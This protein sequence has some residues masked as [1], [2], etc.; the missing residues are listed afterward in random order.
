MVCLFVRLLLPAQ[1]SLHPP[2]ALSQGLGLSILPRHHHHSIG[3]LANSVEVQRF[4]P[5]FSFRVPVKLDDLQKGDDG[6][7]ESEVS[8]CLESA[9]SPVEYPSG[10]RS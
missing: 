9:N 5:Y 2:H 1:T 7:Y 3:Q 8:V 10:Q 4:D 6:D